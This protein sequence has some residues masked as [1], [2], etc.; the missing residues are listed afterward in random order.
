MF[1]VYINR[2][3]NDYAEQTYGRGVALN[4]WRSS[5]SLGEAD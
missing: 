1:I 5:L 4:G 2:K 3:D